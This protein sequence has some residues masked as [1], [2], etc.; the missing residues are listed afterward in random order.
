MILEMWDK[1]GS[2][3]LQWDSEFS[4]AR[5][6]SGPKHRVSHETFEKLLRNFI[7]V[8]DSPS[9]MS[10]RELVETGPY[11]PFLLSWFVLQ[12]LLFYSS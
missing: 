8:D 9:Q 12:P 6:R 3:L 2:E 1:L 11:H 7:A 4:I 10:G 5:I